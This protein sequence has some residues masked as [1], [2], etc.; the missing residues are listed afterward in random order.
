MEPSLVDYVEMHGTGT[1]RGDVAEVSFV[2][3]VF[4]GSRKSMSPLF[5]GSV[6]SNVGHGGAVR[7]FLYTLKINWFF[8]TNQHDT[9]PRLQELHL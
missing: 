9:H 2:A 7:L 3:S 5:I 6:K 1:R 8:F 4:G